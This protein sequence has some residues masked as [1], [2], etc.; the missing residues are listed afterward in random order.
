MCK[1]I[2]ARTEKPDSLTSPAQKHWKVSDHD[3]QLPASEDRDSAVYSGSRGKPFLLPGEPYWR[4]GDT[5][6]GICK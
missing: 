5:M 4:A 2:L 6:E 1:C 3:C